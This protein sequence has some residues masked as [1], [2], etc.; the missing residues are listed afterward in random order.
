M[1]SEPA[2]APTLSSAI[3]YGAQGLTE[4]WVHLFL[5]GEGNNLPFSDG[6][7]LEPRIFYPPESASLNS[8]TRICG[9]EP[10]MKWHEPRDV[11]NRR[12]D[13]LAEKLRSGWDMPPLIV[14]RD[15]NDCELNDGNHRYEALRS[16]KIPEY[17]V[18]TWKSAQTE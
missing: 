7:L 2:Y 6:L 15:E 1:N 4:R 13:A 12:V 10:Q 14:Y 3:A 8:F 18:I 5:R 16:L 9:P 11:F 17:P